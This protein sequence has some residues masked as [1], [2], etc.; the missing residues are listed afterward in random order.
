MADEGIHFQFGKSNDAVNA[1]IGKFLANVKDQAD[2]VEARMYRPLSQDGSPTEQISTYIGSIHGFLKERS[3]PLL[4]GGGDANMFRIYDALSQ[5]GCDLVDR[6]VSLANKLLVTNREVKEGV[7]GPQKEHVSCR[8]GQEGVE[9]L[10]Q[11][12]L[13]GV[14]AL[15]KPL[16]GDV[17]FEAGKGIS[18]LFAKDVPRFVQPSLAYIGFNQVGRWYV[19]QYNAINPKNPERNQDVKRLNGGY[20]SIVRDVLGYA[21]KSMGDLRENHTVSQ[22]RRGQEELVGKIQQRTGAAG[23]YGLNG[24]PK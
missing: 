12:Y 11:M 21:K 1:D 22:L 24:G 6:V 19:E 7:E 5:E 17:F 20:E 4:R 14:L 23:T 8:N 16:R 13:D 2:G 18:E 3:I 15:V 10:P 9:V